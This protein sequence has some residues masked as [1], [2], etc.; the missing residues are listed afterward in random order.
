MSDLEK[1]IRG[2][3]DLLTK[4]G[5]VVDSGLS[6]EISEAGGITLH[7][8]RPAGWSKPLIRLKSEHIIPEAALNTRLSGDSFEID[9]DRRILNPLQIEIASRMIEIYNTAGKVA[10][11]KAE[12]PWIQ[13]RGA[14]HLMEVLLSSLHLGKAKEEKLSLIRGCQDRPSFDE[15]VVKTFMASRTLARQAAETGGQETVIMPIADYLDHDYRG[16]SF[17]FSS[18]SC[19]GDLR[20]FCSQPFVWSQECYARYGTYDAV[21]TFVNYGFIDREVPFVRS[22]PLEIE[23]GDRGRLFIDSRAGSSNRGGE[24]PKTLQDIQF[25]LPDWKRGEYGEF[26]LSHIF[27]AAGCYPR[28]TKRIIRWVIEEM[29]R[30]STDHDFVAKQTAAVEMKILEVNVAYYEKI[31]RV[32]DDDIETKCSLRLRIRQLLDTQLNKLLKYS[33]NEKL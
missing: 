22:I 29:T 17:G 30:D 16:S 6:F 19:S 23:I 13:Y 31:I 12:N 11:H 18:A 14:P 4:N 21:D 27:I 26:K 25:L 33:I 24:I 1:K 28:A 15:F 2:L 32:L 8:R 20:V 9:P 3:I 7:L 10:L 5:S